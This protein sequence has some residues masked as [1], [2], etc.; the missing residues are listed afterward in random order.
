MPVAATD[1]EDI[2]KVS[3]LQPSNSN[4]SNRPVSSAI[5]QDLSDL[6]AKPEKELE[7]LQ[8]EDSDEMVA[9]FDPNSGTVNLVS[10]KRQMQL[11]MPKDSLI[12]EESV[13]LTLK[14]QKDSD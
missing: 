10:S 12:D 6:G 5:L 14:T 7:I 1:F 2:F 13:Y 9:Q 11:E 8:E 3:L 4:A